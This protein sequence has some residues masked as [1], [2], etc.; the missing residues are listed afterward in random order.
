[1]MEHFTHVLE[2]L[3]IRGMSYKQEPVREGRGRA[4]ALIRSLAIHRER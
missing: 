3:T 2:E 1:M 4:R